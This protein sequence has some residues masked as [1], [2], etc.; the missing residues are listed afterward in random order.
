MSKCPNCNA[1]LS[2]G[3]Q[4]RTGPDGKQMCT[5]CL[6]QPKPV[7]KNTNTGK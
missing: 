6:H 7:V 4:K 1:N 2:C 5:K 3:C